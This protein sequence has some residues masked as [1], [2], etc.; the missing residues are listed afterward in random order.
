MNKTNNILKVGKDVLR[1]A[2]KNISRNERK[3]F[4]DKQN[5]K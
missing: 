1:I 3:C 4:W 2:A 5:K